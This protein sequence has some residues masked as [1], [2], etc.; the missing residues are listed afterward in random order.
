MKKLLSIFMSMVLIL[1]LAP[2]T[3]SAAKGSDFAVT[4]NA[5]GY[6]YDADG[7]LTFTQPGAYEVSMASGAMVLP[8]GNRFTI[9]DRIVVNAPASSASAPVSITLSSVNISLTAEYAD[10][11]GFDIKGTSFVNLTL[12]GSNALKPGL[13]LP[14]GTALTIGGDGSL[15]STGIY[16]CAGIGGGNNISGGSIA[17]NSGTVIATSGAVNSS[18]GGAGI[19]GGTRGNGGTVTISGG[20]VTAVGGEGSLHSGGAGIGGGFN[21]DGGAVYISGGSVK[22][23]GHK[24]EAIGKGEGGISSGTL[25]NKPAGE[26]GVPVYLTTVQLAGVNAATAVNSLTASLSGM[27]YTYGTDDMFTDEAGKLYL[28]LPEGTVVSVVETASSRYIGSITTTAD[29]AATGT[30]NSNLLGE[31][32]L[33]GLIVSAGTISPAF[34]SGTYTYTVP[35][36]NNVSSISLTA[37]KINPIATMTLKKDGGTAVLW[38]GTASAQSLDV[39]ENVFTVAVTAQDGITTRTYTVTV[40]RAASSDAALSGLS[41]SQGTLSPS[42]D[43]STYSYTASVANSISSL[44][45]T[46]T[47]SH[48]NATI[49]VNSATVTNGAASGGIPLSEG[50]NTVNIIVTAQDGSTTRTYTVT[51]TRASSDASLSGMTLSGSTLSPA[52]GAC[53]FSYTASV[54]SNISGMTV[55]PTANGTNAT[56]MI[57]GITVPGG[58]ASGSIPLAVGSNTITVVVTAQ[59]GITTQTYTITVTRAQASGGGGAYS[60]AYYTVTATAGAGGNI[61]PSDSVSVSFGSIKTYTIIPDN[62]YEIENVLVDGVSVGAVST[63][64]FENIKK[65]HSIAASF[66]KK[67]VESVNP[68]TDVKK[69]DWFYNNVLFAYES[70]LMTGTGSD[71]FSPNGTTTRGMIVTVLYR[72]SGDKGVNT[73]SFSDVPYGAWY[74]TAAAWV[75]ANGIAGGIGNNQFAPKNSLAREQLAVMLYNYAKYKG[76]DVSVGED[77][78]ILSYNDALTIS[79]YAYSA[80]QWA[81]GAGI[82]N[83]DG[84]GNLN[85]Q[86]S[87][88]RAE[89]AAML[90]RFMKSV[91]LE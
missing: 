43:G 41:I 45:V 39:G 74:E 66:K 86:A 18:Y 75:A 14:E 73:N 3:A 40:A 80:L 83:G 13:N 5:A 2:I 84:S 23:T 46:P 30:L 48:A 62:G 29:S 35:V 37:A 61:S 64:T 52:F 78:N 25:M 28:Y 7:V 65:A 1:S 60:P 56:V 27:P 67:A 20:T 36:A 34:A 85:P 21:G 42:F 24:S 88:T 15:Y 81:C 16:D 53:T 89:V 70:R 8:N 82:M 32:R 68:F 12:V 11:P 87:A 17:I 76:Y 4:G 33:S 50:E 22:A 71:T 72:L 26:G 51:V 44:T 79:D 55:T 91:A 19:G 90:E 31:A 69:D 10:L 57:N 54:A 47:A 6:T 63:Y 59:D 77:T 49:T 58:S 38:D 9:T